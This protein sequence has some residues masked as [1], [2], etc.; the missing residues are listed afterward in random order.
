MHWIRGS[1]YHTG[2][3]RRGDANGGELIS[4]LSGP[5]VGARVGESC[6][7]SSL[8]AGPTSAGNSVGDCCVGIV[9]AG[10]KG[11]GI[12][13]AGTSGIGSLSGEALSPGDSLRDEG[14]VV[15]VV[16]VAEVGELE[17][18]PLN[19]GLNG[20][21]ASPKAT[22]SVCTLLPTLTGSGNCAGGNG[23][24]ALLPLLDVRLLLLPGSCTSSLPAKLVLGGYLPLG[25]LSLSFPL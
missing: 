17:V 23:T 22:G 14:V 9:P 3:A 5:D 25:S 2:W 1:L 21:G 6:R 18:P 10:I 7:A 12:V 11:I 13:P 15:V 24:V 19:L 20:A 16:T 8:L 4:L